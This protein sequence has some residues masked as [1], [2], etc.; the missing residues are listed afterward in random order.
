MI[1][2]VIPLYNKES[3]I[4]A[5]LQSVLRQNGPEFEIVVVNDGST[6]NSVLVVESF[7]DHR[8]NLVNQKKGGPAAARNTG[9]REANGD[10]I[11]FLD[12]DDELMPDALTTFMSLVKKYPNEKCFVCNFYLERD[13]QRKIHSYLYPEKIIKKPFWAWSFGKLLP[14]AGSALFHKDI[15]ARFA[16]DERYKRYEDA[17]WL[18]RIMQENRFVR[19]PKPV[20][21]YNLGSAQASRRRNDIYEDYICNMDLL[22]GTIGERLAK[23]QLFKQAQALYP[24]EAA[25]IYTQRWGPWELLGLRSLD[26]LSGLW[27]RMDRLI[28]KVVSHLE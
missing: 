2:I 7:D 6:D 21:I 8:L 20:M 10:W 22:S 28:R 26:R 3:R 12:A 27:V 1:Y 16:F 14:V 23:Y 5:T 15:T 24:K 13:G 25:S 4:S 18:F 9:I 17:D 11:L 19:C